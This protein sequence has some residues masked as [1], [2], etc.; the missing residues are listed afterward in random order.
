MLLDT[1]ELPAQ[2]RQRAN[3]LVTRLFMRLGASAAQKLP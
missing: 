2:E 3:R 1:P